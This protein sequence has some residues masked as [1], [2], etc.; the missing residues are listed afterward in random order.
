MTYSNFVQLLLH[1]V[2]TTAIIAAICLGPVEPVVSI[3]SG[4]VLAIILNTAIWNRYAADKEENGNVND[5]RG[6]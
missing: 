6:W 5:P 1:L 4:I 2:I 3:P